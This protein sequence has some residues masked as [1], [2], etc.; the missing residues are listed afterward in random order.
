MIQRRTDFTRVIAGAKVQK[1]IKWAD[2]AT[3]VGQ[4]K[5]STKAARPGQMTLDQ[6]QGSTLGKIVGLLD[7]AAAWLQIIPDKGSM[8]SAVPT[9]PLTYRWYEIVTVSGTTIRELIHEECGDGI[10]SAIEVSLDIQRQAHPKGDRAQ[11]P[12][13]RKFLPYK[14]S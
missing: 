1:G 5:E 13:S 3:S 4:S 11:A 10:M 14:A 8:P 6:T 12:L 7:E 2:V 9:D